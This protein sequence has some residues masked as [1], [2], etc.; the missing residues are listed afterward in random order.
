MAGDIQ[1]D[2]SLAQRLQQAEMQR[3]VVQGVGVPLEGPA[4][5]AGVVQGRPVTEPGTTNIP[6]AQA[7]PVVIGTAHAAG[8]PY[9]I[10]STGLQPNPDETV[11]L[12]YRLS[13]QCFT[14]VDALSTLLHTT[15]AI[16]MVTRASAISN[17]RVTYALLGC[18]FL[19]GPVCGYIGARDLRKNLTKVYLAFC[20]AKTIYEIVLAVTFIY[21]VYIL[22]VLVQIWVTKIVFT[23]WRA[24]LRISKERCEQLLNPNLVPGHIHLVYW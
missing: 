1:E 21:W 17:L 8:L 7:M 9:V 18:L 14:V 12:S 20:I 24:L 2:E 10:D 11:V 22:V 13:L 3:A 19:L 23:F 4:S 16:M 6:V 15:P 5:A